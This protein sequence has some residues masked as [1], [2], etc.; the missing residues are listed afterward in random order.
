M[1]DVKANTT[2][3]SFLLKLLKQ[4]QK[5]SQKQNTTNNSIVFANNRA[6]WTCYA[7]TVPH[8]KAKLSAHFSETKDN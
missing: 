3:T 1:N 2:Q 7:Q 4:Q 5:T 6:A 8:W